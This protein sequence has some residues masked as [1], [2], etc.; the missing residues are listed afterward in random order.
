[1]RDALREA[2]ANRATKRND[3]SYF[4]EMVHVIFYAG[5]KA[6]RSLTA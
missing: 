2:A 4:R 6:A 1:M 3:E 5:M